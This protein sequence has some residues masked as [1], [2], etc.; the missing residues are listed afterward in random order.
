MAHLQLSAPVDWS[1]D[2]SPFFL[3]VM[4]SG[5]YLESA[6]ARLKVVAAAVCFRSVVKRFSHEIH[7]MSDDY[8]LSSWS[9][10]VHGPWSM[11][12]DPLDSN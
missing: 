5:H 2:P 8:V 10:A 7:N 12:S 6:T 1:V 4:L 3:V 9:M 11:V